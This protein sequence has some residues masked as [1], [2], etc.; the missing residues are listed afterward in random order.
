[1]KQLLI[2]CL[3]LFSLSACKKH[4]NSDSSPSIVGKWYVTNEVVKSYK[5]GELV[6]NDEAKGDGKHFL[7]LNADKT[8][9]FYY[10]QD[11]F[12]LTYSYTPTTLTLLLK[13][14]YNN[15]VDYMIK[16]LTATELILHQESKGDTWQEDHDWYFNK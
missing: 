14:Q 1:M 5:N 12:N 6:K 10:I 11:N 15:R 3:L 4:T 13:N 7:L 8:G 2:I 9:S 16:S